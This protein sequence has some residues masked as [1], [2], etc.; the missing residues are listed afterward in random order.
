MTG[1]D[2]VF[3]VV[4]AL[5]AKEGVAPEELDYTLSEYVDTDALATLAS[6]E[7]SVWEFSFRVK[8][9]S[10]TVT[11]DGRAYVDGVAYRGG[12]RID[13]PAHH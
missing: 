1:N 5:A 9:H 13:E 3:E 2:I 10:V 6:M 4:A 7:D 12:L 8:D 11:H